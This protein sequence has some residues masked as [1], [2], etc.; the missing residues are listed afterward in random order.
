MQFKTCR[1]ICKQ[2][3]TQGSAVCS[4][5]TRLYRYEFRLLNTNITSKKRFATLQKYT[6][7]FKRTKWAT[8]GVVNR[9]K[10]FFNSKNCIMLRFVFIKLCKIFIIKKIDKSIQKRS[11]QHV[12]FH[13]VLSRFFCIY[14]L[15]HYAKY[16]YPEKNIARNRQKNEST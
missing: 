9:F 14:L 8:L 3:K 13:I 6:I 16:F 15:L 12:R 2:N 4:L 5:H 11:L 1:L 10:S 7:K